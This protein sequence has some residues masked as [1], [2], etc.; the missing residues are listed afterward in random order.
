MI[1][2]PSTPPAAAGAAAAP[3]QDPFQQLKQVLQDFRTFL[4]Q[5]VSTIE[6][7]IRPLRSI[8]PQINDLIDK[9][10]GLMTSLK[11]EIDKLNPGAIPGLGQVTTFTGKIST[12]LD[13]VKTILPQEGAA[14]DDVR[15]ALSVVGNL[16]NLDQIKTELLA[17]ID[18]INADLNRLK[19]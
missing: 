19:G 7:A 13:S 16:Q 6:A 2:Q 17:L 10:I 3:A 8:L 5:N 12:M 14:I 4:D 11:S 9:L 15:T 18:A 1:T